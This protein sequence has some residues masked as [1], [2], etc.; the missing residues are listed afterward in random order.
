MK[1]MHILVD[2]PDKDAASIIDNEQDEDIEVIDLS[3]GD[4]SYDELVDKIEQCDKV[5]TW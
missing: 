2:G 5:I 3:Q 1:V 4:I